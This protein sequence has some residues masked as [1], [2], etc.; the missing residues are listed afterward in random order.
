MLGASLEERVEEAEETLNQHEQDLDRFDDRLTRL[1]R[2]RLQAIGALK[3][4]AL[5]LG[6]GGL[7]YIVESITGLV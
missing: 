6:A 1:E 5:V 7:A 2:F 4:I 3:T